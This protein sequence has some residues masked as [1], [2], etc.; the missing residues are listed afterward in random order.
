M[1]IDLPASAASCD[2]QTDHCTI[3]DNRKPATVLLATNEQD[4]AD[5]FRNFVGW[6]RLGYTR[7]IIVSSCDEA[8]AQLAANK[9]NAIAVALPTKESARL[10]DILHGMHMLF[11][12]PVADSHAL[13]DVLSRMS[14]MIEKQREPAQAGPVLTS[15]R[16]TFFNT[17]LDG[18]IHSET[19][20]RNRI[21]VIQLPISPDCPCVLYT[22]KM[23]GAD[24]YLEDVW[25][26]GRARLQLALRKF[27]SGETD[28]LYMAIGSIRAGTIRLIC[29]PANCIDFGV[30]VEELLAKSKRAVEEKIASVLDYIELDLTIDSQK[31]LSGLTHLLSKAQHLI[32]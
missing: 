3:Q 15:I 14:L 5:N 1:N 8:A 10:H 28:G 25:Q 16:D 30:D 2:E 23:N 29:C 32:I 11:L 17:L 31:L 13:S 4:V 6:E 7:P 22:L 26:Y 27:F 18:L 19:V 12:E 20:L 21:Q 24:H 9:V